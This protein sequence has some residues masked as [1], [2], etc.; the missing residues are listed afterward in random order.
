MP[1]TYFSN[2]ARLAQQALSY[3][4]DAG[5]GARASTHL[6]ENA[7]DVLVHGEN[8]DAERLS[9]LLVRRAIGNEMEDRELAVSEA[10]GIGLDPLLDLLVQ[11]VP[12]PAPLI[13]FLVPLDRAQVAP[14]EQDF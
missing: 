3:A 1:D 8:A 14:D 12:D 10:V 11:V 2:G 7:A 13:F 6:R 9:D 5:F 4:P